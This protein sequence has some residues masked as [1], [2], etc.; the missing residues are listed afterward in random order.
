MNTREIDDL[1]FENKQLKESLANYKSAYDFMV[2]SGELL[3]GLQQYSSEINRKLIVENERLRKSAEEIVSYFEGK[4]EHGI[5]KFVDL[6]DNLRAALETK[7]NMPEQ[8]EK[9]LSKE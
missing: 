3:K 8:Q 2:M 4:S 1:K 5:P 6:I 9:D 7:A